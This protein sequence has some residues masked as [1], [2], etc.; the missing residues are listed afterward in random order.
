MMG[1]ENIRFDLT[2]Q[3]IKFK[4]VLNKEFV[5]M[6][7]WA[8]STTDPNRRQTHFTKESLDEQIEKK[9]VQNKPIVAFFEN[10]DFTTHEGKTDYD[11]EYDQ[12]YWNVEKGERLL[13]WVRES[14]PVEVVEKKG[15]YWLKFR[16]ILCVKYCYNQVKRLL[17]DKSKKV[18]VE[19]KTLKTVEREDGVTDIL[20]FILYG[21]TILGS[22]YGKK[23]LEAVPDAHCTILDGYS[24]ESLADQK[25]MLCF[26]YEEIGGEGVV[27]KEN[28]VQEEIRVMEH[29]ELENKL[30]E[31]LEVFKMPGSD[32]SRYSIERI[33]DTH[34][35]VFDREEK[36]MYKIKYEI[37]DDGN[38]YLHM[39]EMKDLK[40]IDELMSNFSV[41]EDEAGTEAP[42]EVNKS[43]EAMSTKDWG[44]VD[45]TYIRERVV[46][47]ENFKTIAK[48]VFLDLREGWEDGNVTALKY[49]VMEIKGDEA[50]YNRNALA[51]AKAYATQHDDK[52]V[53]EKLEEIYK[54]LDLKED[55]EYTIICEEDSFC[56]LYGDGCDC[57]KEHEHETDDEDDKKEEGVEP[58]NHSCEED[59]CKECTIDPGSVSECH[60]EPLK[61]EE[62]GEP[63]TNEA[64]PLIEEGETIE[65]F[66]CQLEEMTASCEE[67]RCKYE[68]ANEECEKYK[69]MYNAMSEDYGKLKA[70]YDELENKQQQFADYEEIKERMVKAEKTVWEHFCKDLVDYATEKMYGENIK[71]DDV[72][73]IMSKCEKG[74]YGCHEDVDKDI[75]YAI[76]KARPQNTEKKFSVFMPQE[77]RPRNNHATTREE[78]LAANVK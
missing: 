63:H 71:E 70:S 67:Y 3:Q 54:D 41:K 66:K 12:K 13:G 64:A 37:I 45:K 32:W 40:E 39:G 55:K 23:V 31:E 16:C 8:I 6:E 24:Q 58:E 35:V 56:N 68:A 44:S 48:D 30:W 2:S 28:N 60:P 73:C 14:D 34:I 46:K 49:P 18:S 76:Y 19:I 29:R 61:M 27:N 72:S 50:V 36:I 52:A 69:N 43:K 57:E 10:N 4:N 51:A 15:L 21:V 20:S 7:V 65:N 22:K 47:A 77:E 17:K 5:E 53:L 78:R 42:I 9:G 25:Q 11:N 26:A 1:E 62:G 75:A 33:Y 38:V 59:P 74:E